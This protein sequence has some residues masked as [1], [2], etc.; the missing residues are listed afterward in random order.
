MVAR[1]MSNIT[2]SRRG[3]LGVLAAG[4]AAPRASRNAC[5][6]VLNEGGMSQVDTFDPKPDAPREVRSPFAPIATR[7]SFQITGLFPRHAAIGDK[8]SIVRS[9]TSGSVAL[10]D[11]AASVLSVRLPGVDTGNDTL[12]EP[13]RVRERYGVNPLGERLLSARRLV[14]SGERLVTVR[15]GPV[16]DTHGAHPYCTMGDLRDTIAPM[17]DRAFAA[18]ISDLDE[19]G[20]LETTLVAALTEFGRTPWRNADGGREHW[21]GCWSV[22]FAGGGVV[23]GQVIGSSD[24]LGAYPVER[25][26]EPQQ[27]IA[28]IYKALGMAAENGVAPINE[29]F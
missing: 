2:V 7:G 21:A 18:L 26:V 17:Y 14:E 19:R 27:L 28:T 29:L 16:W 9:V 25:P 3:F 10:H 6:L 23:G 13:L 24:E 12:S 20:M 4:L 11:V 22:C 15:T 1:G 5:I 8:F